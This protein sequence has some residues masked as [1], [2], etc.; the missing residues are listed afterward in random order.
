MTNR[1]LRQQ[2]SENIVGF[3]GARLQS[4]YSIGKIFRSLA[5]IATPLFKR[6]VKAVGKRALQTATEVGQEKNA[7][8]SVKSRGKQAAGDVAK[9]AVNKVMTA[10]GRK[11]RI[12]RLAQGTATIRAQTEKLKTS[13]K[14]DNYKPRGEWKLELF[15]VP[16]TQV[17]IEME[18]GFWVNIYPIT[19]FTA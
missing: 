6:G 14:V 5:G 12:Q 8:E 17:E 2:P 9:A 16:P 1:Y 19:S 13:N 10:L 15:S 7:I 3:C 4:G 18:K 11:K